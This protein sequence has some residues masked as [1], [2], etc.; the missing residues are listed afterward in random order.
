MRQ[1]TANLFLEKEVLQGRGSKFRVRSRTLIQDKNGERPLGDRVRFPEAYQFGEHE[2]SV[3]LSR[4][5]RKH[6]IWLI[7]VV[8]ESIADDYVTA[9]NPAKLKKA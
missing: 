8:E 9:F 3:D 7:D 5:S 4:R 2:Y 1:P 6:E